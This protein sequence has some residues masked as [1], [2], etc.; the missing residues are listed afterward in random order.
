MSDDVAK[1]TTFTCVTCKK[2]QPVA[3]AM[4]GHYCTLQCRASDGDSGTDRIVMCRNKLCHT[5]Y[6]K[7]KKK[8]TC[9]VTDIQSGLPSIWHQTNVVW[10][11]GPQQY[12]LVCCTDTAGCYAA[13]YIR[14]E[15]DPTDK[16]VT[17]KK[18]RDAIARQRPEYSKSRYNMRHK[19]KCVYNSKKLTDLGVTFTP[20]WPSL[21]LSRKKRR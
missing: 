4:E 7:M 10:L 3:S 17:V 9:P 12:T 18:L 20:Y 2:T 21:S 5:C 14:L 16:L 1:P 13:D 19:G 11:G 8:D 15:I 6:S